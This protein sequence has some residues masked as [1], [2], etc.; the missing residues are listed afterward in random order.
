MRR[1]TNDRARPLQAVLQAA[2]AEPDL[3]GAWTWQ[4]REDL[5]FADATILSLFGLDPAGAETGV[6]IAAFLDRI[7]P[8]DRPEVARRREQCAAAGTSYVAEYR[9]RLPDGAVRWV[10]A[11]GRFALDAAGRPLIGRGIM[12]DMT[13]SPLGG[14]VYARETQPPAAHPLERAADC[15]LAARAAIDEAAQPFLRRLIDLVLLEL[16][17]HL[18]MRIRADRRSRMN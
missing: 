11:R 15:C 1:D 16:G 8:E 2:L 7:H 13:G 10:L 14:R 18:A 6:P 17:R 4:P 12:L 9:I 5:I 3:L